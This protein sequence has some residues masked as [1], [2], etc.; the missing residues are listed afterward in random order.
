MEEGKFHKKHAFFFFLIDLPL[1]YIW[2]TA[3][4]IVPSLV[5]AFVHIFSPYSGGSFP[6]EGLPRSAPYQ[7]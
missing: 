5:Y 3:E 1:L 7:L 4:Y 2:R 6:K